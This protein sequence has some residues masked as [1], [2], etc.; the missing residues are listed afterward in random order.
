MIRPH[1]D[2]HLIQLN[3]CHSPISRIHVNTWEYEDHTEWMD[4]IHPG[5]EIVVYAIRGLWGTNVVQF[6][7]ID[8][9]CAW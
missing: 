7:R 4:E 6:A 1:F 5:D 2:H 3:V 8:V 9:Y